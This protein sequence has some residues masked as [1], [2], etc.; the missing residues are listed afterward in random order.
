MSA[1]APP[2]AEVRAQLGPALPPPWR[3]NCPDG[4]M[5]PWDPECKRHRPRSREAA[6]AAWAHLRDLDLLDAEGWQA[7][8]LAREGASC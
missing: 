4:C 8:L 7:G 2:L 1:A 5:S 6:R 3:W